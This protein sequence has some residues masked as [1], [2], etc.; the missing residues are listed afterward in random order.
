MREAQEFKNEVFSIKYKYFNAGEG[1]H[2]PVLIKA[3]SIS[4]GP[5]LELGTGF[6]STAVIHWLCNHAKRKID[7]YE[8]VLSFY[9]I[10]LNYQNDFHQVHFI[11][12]WDK[13]PI[14]KHWGVV[15]LDHAPGPRRNV[16]MLR[17]ANNAD[18]VIVHDTE[19]K[20]D[21]HYHFTNHF[22]KYKYRFDFTVAYPHTSVF[23]NFKDLSEFKDL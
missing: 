11:E 20:S 9:K 2:I 21:W 12:D 3:L 19:P 6:N 22:D 15:F 18:Y 1:S 23:S 13:L 5:I 16:E 8:S 4:Q 17:F 7:S 10:A 14:D